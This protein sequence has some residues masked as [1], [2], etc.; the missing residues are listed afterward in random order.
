MDKYSLSAALVTLALFHP[1]L[2]G[3]G[4]PQ[5]PCPGETRPTYPELD[6]APV[7]HF[8]GDSDFGSDWRPPVC[9]GWTEAGF[10]S[11]VAVAG[12]FR[13]TS[14][15]E[16]LLRRVA[17]VSELSGIRYWST[18]RQRW[19][20]LI[21]SAYAVTAPAQGQRRRDFSLDEMKKGKAYYFE[22]ED[23]LSGAAVYRL[24]I[25]EVSA[26]RLVFTIE[27]V[28]PLRRFHITLFSP[29]EVQSVYFLDRETDGV[30]RY[31]SLVRTGRNSSRLA[32]G[33]EASSTNRAVAFYRFLVGI[34]T[35]L[36]PP[37]AR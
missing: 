4:G 33:H 30:W 20:A 11:L 18:T 2:R 19:Q 6:Q 7:V 27:N 10:S 12:R 22:Q 8:W 23:N 34:P 37:M 32:A 36:E 3:Q 29:G 15:V 9:I 28:T 21:V 5:P 13:H 14:E 1:E 26:G 16:G 35:D 31:Y 25:A 24:Q 17:A